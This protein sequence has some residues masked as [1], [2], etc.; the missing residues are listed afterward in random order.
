MELLDSTPSPAIP[1]S[2]NAT[3]I[4]FFVA[5]LSLAAWAPLIPLAKERLMADHGTMG[6]VLLSFGIGSFLMMPLSGILASRFGCRVVFFTATILTLAMMPALVTM[7]TPLTLAI[8]LFLFGAG[9]GAMDVVVNIHAV[10]VEKQVD[11]PVMSGFHALFSIGG[12][13]GAGLVSLLLMQGLAP[14]TVIALIIA[15]VVIMLLFAYSGMLTYS[16]SDE[17]PLFVVPKG[18]VILLGVLCFVAYIMEGSMLDWSGILL[19]SNNLITVDHA[20]LG[21]TVFACA[22]TAG[23]LL[24]DRIIAAFGRL[25]VFVISA[26]IASLGFGVIVLGNSLETMIGGFFLIGAGL[27]NIV[28]ILFTA[29]GQQ[30]VMPSTLAV[31][32]VSTI[33]Y[34]GILLGP[35]LIG[36][37]ANATTL[38][39]AFG[40]VAVLSL[41]L[42]ICARFI[43]SAND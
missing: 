15:A 8:A 40:V 28:P 9:I 12:I 19:T 41:S 21:Y 33:G 31:A 34:S 1:R 13:A 25:R 10:L 5:G 30:K 23:R 18:I 38:G 16:E 4:A 37:V 43:F 36:F 11:K 3:R 7:N 32:S 6:M 29:S 14:L 24:G 26:L 17:S 39:F 35:A 27:S 42:L 22:M 20:G 2:V